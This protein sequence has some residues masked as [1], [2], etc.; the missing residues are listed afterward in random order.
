MIQQLILDGKAAILNNRNIRIFILRF[1]GLAILWMLLYRIIWSST[2][3]MEA[4]RAMSLSVISVILNTTA[5]FLELLG[6]ETTIVSSARLVK[7]VGTSG[8]T[9]GEPCIGYGVMAFFVGLI[10]A[11][12][13]RIKHKLWYIPLGLLIIYLVNV[14]RIVGLALLV[15]VDPYIWEV[16]HKLIFK[17]IVYSVVF[18]LWD[19]WMKMNKK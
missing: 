9:V 5:F 14:F 15:K 19:R 13:S 12:P 3:L 11:Y 8:V 2:D 6:Q 10:L 4:Y 1:L 7:V 17:L 16:N 18:L